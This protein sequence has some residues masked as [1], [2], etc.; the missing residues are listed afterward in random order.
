M[1]CGAGSPR[2]SV[3]S[4]KYNRCAL[5]RNLEDW[6]FLD[7]RPMVARGTGRS[8]ARVPWA[9]RSTVEQSCE[10]PVNL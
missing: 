5:M 7:K 10:V 2:S 9:L 4:L 8:A 6:S 1:E 3:Q